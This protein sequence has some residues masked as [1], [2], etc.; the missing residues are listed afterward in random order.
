MAQSKETIDSIFSNLDKS[1]LSNT[2][3]IETKAVT[4]W[5]PEDYKN[6]F[7]LLQEKS[8]KKVGKLIQRV[9]KES[10]DRLDLD[11]I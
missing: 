11:A 8:G 2:P 3:S 1:L 7:D 6:K 5:L 9:I 4:F 10:L